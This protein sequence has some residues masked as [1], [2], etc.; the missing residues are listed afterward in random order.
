MLRL[1]GLKKT[2]PGFRLELSLEVQEGEILALLGPS[3]SGKSTILRLIA[4]LETPERGR[5]WLDDR[6]LTPLPPERRGVGLVFQDYA[7]FPHLSVF[8]NVAFGLREQHLSPVEVRRRVEELLERTE[9]SAQAKKRP[10]QLSG[11][12]QQRVALCRALAPRPRV[13]LLDEP[14]GALDRNLR[15]ELLPWLRQLLRESK[16]TA[17]VVTHDQLEAF[18][19]AQRIALLRAGRLI[20]IDTAE[21]IFRRPRTP[22]VARFLGQRNL[23]DPAASAA[24][25]LPARPHL[26]PPEALRLGGALRARVEE[27][28]FLGPRV[29]LWLSWRDLRWY[30]EGEDPG[31]VEG[32]ELAVDLQLQAAWPLEEE[33]MV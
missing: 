10:H 4:G 17:V 14:L 7:L 3:G 22:W 25:G 18:V 11:G 13:L 9:L 28:L 19:L 31:V 20:Q 32:E 15:E 6:E 33:V 1:E 12:E 16:T 29:G 24:L 30:W 5:I 2:F 23:L 26:L 27:R 21:A 8:E